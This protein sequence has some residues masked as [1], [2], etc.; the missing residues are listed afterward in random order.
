M[1]KENMPEITQ[2]MRGTY[3]RIN[4]TK[5]PASGEGN[6]SLESARSSV[7]VDQCVS[8]IRAVEMPVFFCLR[9]NCNHVTELGGPLRFVDVVLVYV[10]R[11]HSV[12]TRF[13]H[14]VCRWWHSY[15]L[16]CTCKVSDTNKVQIF[17]SF[18]VHIA[19]SCMYFFIGV[20][21]ASYT[22]T[23][24]TTTERA[25]SELRPQMVR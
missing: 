25:A 17:I 14:T 21:L 8:A 16:W 4:S 6:V 15:V 1:T 2:N 20:S 22:S 19:P 3:S 5:S 9:S 24:K 18:C 7:R 12:F 23:F 11:S 10:A 13:T